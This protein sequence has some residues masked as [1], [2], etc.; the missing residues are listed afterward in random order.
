MYCLL[1]VSYFWR[2][3][4]WRSNI[5]VGINH[6]WK[7]LG[8]CFIWGM[9]WIGIEGF[10]RFG[11]CSSLGLIWVLLLSKKDVIL[12]RIISYFMVVWWVLINHNRYLMILIS[13]NNH[14]IYHEQLC[15]RTRMHLEENYM[16]C[17]QIIWVNFQRYINKLI[18]HWSRYFSKM[19]THAP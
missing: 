14:R 4:F 6:V 3:V 2:N 1:F 15:Y 19:L 11:R 10:H 17:M 5:K 8:C 7:N 13:L 12:I 18:N 9:I 16:I